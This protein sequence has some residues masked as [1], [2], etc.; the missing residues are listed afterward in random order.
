MK[1]RNPFKQKPQKNETVFWIESNGRQW[2]WKQKHIDRH[3]LKKVLL[4]TL[5]DLEN[6]DDASNRKEHPDE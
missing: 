6:K 1:I 3:E 5:L 2:V 4:T